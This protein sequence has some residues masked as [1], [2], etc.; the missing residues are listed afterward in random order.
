[1]L[2][3]QVKDLHSHEKLQESDDRLNMLIID[4]ELISYIRLE[5]RHSASRRESEGNARELPAAGG[6][7]TGAAGSAVIGIGGE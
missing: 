1:M 2:I 7:R 3:K 4:L 6:E 5:D